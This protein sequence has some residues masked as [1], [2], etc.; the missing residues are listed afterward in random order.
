MTHDHAARDLSRR[1]LLKL[2]GATGVL[3]AAGVGPVEAQTPKRGGIFRLAGFDPPHFDPH[4]TPHWWTPINY[5]SPSAKV[6]GAWEPYVKNYMPNVGNDYG[7]RM[8]AAWL[9]K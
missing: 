3:A 1:E 4:Q 7:G 6:V 8:M 9:D 2:A 5:P